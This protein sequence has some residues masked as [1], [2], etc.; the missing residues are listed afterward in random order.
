MGASP[1]RGVG[2]S[3]LT[4]A[5]HP[6]SRQFLLGILRLSSPAD[7]SQLAN[8]HPQVLPAPNNP[9]SASLWLQLASEKVAHG[10][11]LT[12]SELRT[13]IGISREGERFEKD[14]AFWPQMASV[15]LLQ[16]AKAADAT[17]EWRKASHC[18]N[19]NDQQTKMLQLDQK[20]LALLGNWNQAGL[21]DT[22]IS[23]VRTL[24]QS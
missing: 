9:L 16:A 17:A 5:L 14:N 20:R 2:W 13:L 19:W 3:T 22:C 11:K 12:S 24:R 7:I 21:T 18:Q 8:L 23:H 15:F 10:D 4:L 6:L 1:A